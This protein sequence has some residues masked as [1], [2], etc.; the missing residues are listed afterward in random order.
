MKSSRLFIFII[1]VSVLPL[2]D[3]FLNPGLPHTS[4]GAMH[5]ARFAAYYK[6]FTGG[7]FPVRWASQFN[8]GYGTPIFNFFHPLPYIIGIPFIAAGA[9][10]VNTLKIGF[11]I[12]YLLS[13]IF[14][15]MFTR[16][17]FKDD[18]KALLVTVMYQFAPF[19]LV[20]MLVRG[21]LGGLYSYALLPLVLYGL[22]KFNGERK[23]RY[24]CLIAVAAALLSMSHNIVGFVFFGLCAIFVFF[25]NREWKSR[26]GLFSGMVLGLSLAAAYLIPAIIEHKYTNGY[27]FTKDLFYDHFTPLYK[28]LMP[29]FFNLPSLRIAE[30]A[31]QFGFFHVIALI[32]GAVWLYKKS[33]NLNHK[34]Y[35][36]SLA[37][38]VITL[39][40]MS[41]ISL[42]FWEKISVL[43]QFQYPWRL[44]AVICFTTAMASVAFFR[45]P[46]FKQKIP[47]WIMI[48][49]IIFSTS[50]YWTPYQGYLKADQNFYWNYPLNTNYYGEV[51]SIWM[52]NEPNSYPA[53][54]IEVV[55]GNAV[56]SNPDYKTLVHKFNLEVSKDAVILDNTQFYPGW[57]VTANNQSVPIEFQN[58]NHRGLITF[59]L[60]SGS[61]AVTVRYSESKLE[62]ISDFLS[63]ITLLLMFSGLLFQSRLDRFF[64]KHL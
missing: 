60:P 12:S 52:G 14:M 64:R 21:S 46:V 36:F 13:G 38:T 10:L 51:N 7:Q 16:A 34:I 31:V 37:I 54:R 47:F 53:N 61:Y 42:I 43:R 44:L 4:D 20:E 27:L 48:I 3:I 49:F 45:I 35:V 17:F 55:S 62:K 9:S 23:Y 26:I 24:F 1:A 39:F 59:T 41:G 2:I 18:K 33:D 11:A 25:L 30:V 5:L 63:A 40:F 32:L 8:Y 57:K 29:N 6:E 19:R 50:A 28:F 22:V 56:I 15:L 58:Q